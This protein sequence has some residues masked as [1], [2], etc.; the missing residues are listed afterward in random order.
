M[1]VT[2]HL[3]LGLLGAGKTTLL[4]HLLDGQYPD[5]APAVL[6]G[7]FAEVGFDG[8]RLRRAATVVEIAGTGPEAA[9]RYARALAVLLDQGPV[10]RVIVEASGAADA[11]R[12]L[13]ALHADERLRDEVRWG[14]VVTVLDAGAHAGLAAAFPEAIDAQVRIADVI[15]LNKLDRL[16]DDAA[17]EALAAAIRAQNPAAEVV[18]AYQGQV[19]TSLVFAPRADDRL[20]ASIGAPAADFEAF[21]YRTDRVCYDL[22]RFGHRLLYPAAGR[23]ARFKGVVRAWDQTWQIS[24]VPGQLDWVPAP[25]PRSTAIAL[26]GPGLAEY[27]ESLGA[28]LDA[29]LVRQSKG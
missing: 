5:G 21:V 18:L 13:A 26:I 9:E 24:G 1:T 27:R 4:E 16:P 2:V 25:E 23:L 19:R 15:V 3:V 17:R 10:R 14:R 7:E 22:A 29:E 12:L 11:G 20:P 8:E 6:V 28:D